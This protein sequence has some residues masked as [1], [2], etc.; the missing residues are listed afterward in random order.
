MLVLAGTLAQAQRKERSRTDNPDASLTWTLEGRVLDE[1]GQPVDQAQVFCA[2][3]VSISDPSIGG[4]SCITDKNGTFRVTVST[5][6]PGTAELS[7]RIHVHHDWFLPTTSG[8]HAGAPGTTLRDIEIRLK[9]G[10]NISGRV[11][12]EDGKPIKNVNVA[13]SWPRPQD[14]RED[15]KGVTEKEPGDSR[16]PVKG[17][18]KPERP[19]EPDVETRSV[20][21]DENGYYRIGGLEVTS[22]KLTLGGGAWQAQTREVTLEAGRHLTGQDAKLARLTAV[23]G[24]VAQANWPLSRNVKALFY[25]GDT[26]VKECGFAV[27]R[28]RSFVVMNPP[29]GTYDL[30]LVFAEHCSAQRVRVTIEENKHAHVGEITLQSRASVDMQD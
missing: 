5:S 23:T 27:Y 29:M 2:A 19:A 8:P 26:V 6:V 20:G 15:D 16:P 18:P 11:T 12:D 25:D 22:V 14:S 4:N 30:W 13:L 3:E 10:A 24:T 9:P 7:C 1:S 28:D 21:T 17:P